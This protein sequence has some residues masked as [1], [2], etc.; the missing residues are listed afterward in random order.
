M[1]EIHRTSDGFLA[2]QMQELAPGT[3]EALIA[4]LDFQE[5]KEARGYWSVSVNHYESK[6]DIDGYLLF[7]FAERFDRLEGDLVMPPLAFDELD[8][9]DTIQQALSEARVRLGYEARGT[10]LRMFQD[11]PLANLPAFW[12]DSH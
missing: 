8:A 2:Y 3:G 7:K 6:E 1:F 10:T 12:Y 4:R 5:N 11:V 9:Y